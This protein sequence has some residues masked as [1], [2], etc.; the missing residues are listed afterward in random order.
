M[1][2]GY[3]VVC[4]LSFQ[5]LCVCVRDMWM[6]R[7]GAVGGNMCISHYIVCDSFGI[8]VFGACGGLFVACAGA[9][10]RCLLLVVFPVFLCVL[11]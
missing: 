3:R 10:F 2:G 9:G 5:K 8:S 11:W 1:H 7:G 6:D 4:V